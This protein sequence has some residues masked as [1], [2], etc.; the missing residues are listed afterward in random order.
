MKERKLS[1]NGTEN[2]AIHDEN[3]EISMIKENKNNITGKLFD[4]SKE[5]FVLQL[6]PTR[7]TL[8]I[9]VIRGL[10]GL[11]VAV[12]STQRPTCI[13]NAIDCVHVGRCVRVGQLPRHVALVDLNE[14][15]LTTSS[16]DSHL[17]TL[18]D[19]LFLVPHICGGYKFSHLLTIRSVCI[20]NIQGE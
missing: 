14:A 15:L 13:S 1:L 8:P 12:Q 3:L 11:S 10:P 7:S 18:L 9:R 5:S 17:Y 6:V 20:P 2:P 4:G 19:L 16:T